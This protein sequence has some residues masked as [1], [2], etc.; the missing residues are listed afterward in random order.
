MKIEGRLLDKMLNMMIEKTFQNW[1]Q[2]H[3]P[4]LRI[5]NK[6]NLPKFK[7]LPGKVLSKLT[8][9]KGRGRPRNTDIRGL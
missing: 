8:E 3:L 5:T 2:K 4:P 7:L 1:R 9:Y 6:E